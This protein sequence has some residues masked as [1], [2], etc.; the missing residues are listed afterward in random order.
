MIPTLQ[1]EDS[2]WSEKRQSVNMAVPLAEA[3]RTASPTIGPSTSPCCPRSLRP[4][5]SESRPRSRSGQPVPGTSAPA[6]AA[7]LKAAPQADDYVEGLARLGIAKLP[8]YEP[9]A[10]VHHSGPGGGPLPLTQLARGC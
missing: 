5:R 2:S 1:K 7:G 4:P 9:S 10:A 8:G 6:D 3:S